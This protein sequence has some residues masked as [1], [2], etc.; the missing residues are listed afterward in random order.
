MWVSYRVFGVWALPDQVL[1]I[2]LHA[3]VGVLLFELLL[4]ANPTRDPRLLTLL[5]LVAL[6]SPYTTSGVTWISDRPQLGV[7]ITLLLVVRHLY[8]SDRSRLGVVVA[9]SVLAL[10]SKESGIIVPALVA[11][12]GWRRSRRSLVISG[13]VLIA[14]Y[15]AL[16][17]AIFGGD[18]FA[19]SESGVLFGIWPYDDSTDLQGIQRIT[20]LIDNVV[21]HLVA[22]GLPVFDYQGELLLHR[23]LWVQAPL[24]LSTAGLVI[25][26][27]TLRPSRAQR[28]A[29]LVMVANAV[30][31][32]AAFRH[33][34]LYVTQLAFVAFVAA[35]T[36]LE[37]QRRRRLM[38]VLA[39]VLLAFSTFRVEQWLVGDVRAG[40]ERLRSGQ[41][42]GSDA[43][44]IDPAIV[45]AV[46]RVYR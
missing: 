44:E 11:I 16:R 21:K 18:A 37:S 13:T 34:G 41:L 7:A 10:L 14:G 19:Y 42:A 33:R 23:P 2:V 4:R 30:I 32:A 5:V 40:Y 43:P 28:V 12:E 27:A 25:L 35:S 8:F 20:M 29:V 38:T 36:A 17:V 22:I 46:E 15:L 26:T 3:L 45:A 6:V 39:A 24:W 9:L 1:S 31:H